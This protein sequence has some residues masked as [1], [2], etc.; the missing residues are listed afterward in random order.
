MEVFSLRL[1]LAGVLSMKLLVTTQ[2]R[3][4]TAISTVFIS[5]SCQERGSV[6]QNTI[7]LMASSG[8]LVEKRLRF[9][10]IASVKPLFK[11]T[12]DR[13][14]KLASLIPLAL[15]A[16]EPRH[17]HCRAEFQDLLLCRWAMSIA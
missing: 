1:N 10:Q 12:V 13:S 17:A 6:T 7:L 3:A 9:L 14:E 11:P 16:Q 15:T 2:D 8:Q 5:S 4:T